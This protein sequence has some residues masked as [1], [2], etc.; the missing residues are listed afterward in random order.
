MSIEGRIAVDVGFSDSTSSTGTQSLKRLSLASTDNYTTGKVA[1]V[2]GTCS[3]NAVSIGFSPTTYK[4]ASGT[5]VS[6]TKVNRI[7]FAA[8]ASGSA[9]A[10]CADWNVDVAVFS[11][12]GRVAVTDVDV[13]QGGNTFTVNVA[14]TSGT[15]TYTLV[16]YG[17]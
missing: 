2:T 5:A 11:S 7:S 13:A 16:M 4:D 14:G 17:T 12:A 9:Y 1:I 10:R 8:T 15:A 6:F 3:T